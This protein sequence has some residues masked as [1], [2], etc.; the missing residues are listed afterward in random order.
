MERAGNDVDTVMREAKFAEDEDT[1]AQ[2]TQRK[3]TTLYDVYML[4]FSYR[5]RI[6]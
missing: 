5:G 2:E 4:I 3:S 6:Q 1:K